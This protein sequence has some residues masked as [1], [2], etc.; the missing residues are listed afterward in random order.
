MLA[1]TD[2]CCMLA[3]PQVHAALKDWALSEQYYLQAAQSSEVRRCWVGT[4]TV[5]PLFVALHSQ[6]LRQ[7]QQADWHACRCHPACLQLEQ[8]MRARA[9]FG[10]AVAMHMQQ[11]DETAIDAFKKAADVAQS[12][13]WCRQG[14]ETSASILAGLEI[15]IAWGCKLRPAKPLLAHHSHGS[16]LTSP[17]QTSCAC[18]AGCPRPPCTAS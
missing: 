2:C 7:L 9:W 4:P 3:L 11:E 10:A 12:G 5:L 14:F 6:L 13:G 16:H 17:V 18:A 15:C 1:S 8:Q